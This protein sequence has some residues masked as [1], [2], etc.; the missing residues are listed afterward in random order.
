VGCG[1]LGPNVARAD[2][3]VSFELR[4][5]VA[6]VMLPRH[7]YDVTGS[8]ATGTGLAPAAVYA[9]PVG[10]R[11]NAF[12]AGVGGR[13]GYRLATT[14]Q[15]E[16]T[17]TWWGFRMAAGLD[18]DLLYG[19]VDTGTEDV[20][21]MLCARIKSDGVQP[22]FQGSSV[23][24]TQASAFLGGEVGLGKLGEESSWHGVVVGAGLAPAVG[25][26]KPWVSGGDV[27]GG[28][29]GLELSVDFATLVPGTA[30]LTSKRIA[31]FLL[32]P[33]N[34]DAPVVVTAS[35]GLVFY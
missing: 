24:L 23:V 27:A 18:L 17:S 2:G 31:V 9:S 20:S 30:R 21:G 16:G 12:G 7:H 15:G 33:S 25:I 8:C 13:I 29:L 32:L 35:F 22:A 10:A 3:N 4:E 34:D 5:Q 11:G 26:F 1:W 28:L 6:G 14:P 19:H